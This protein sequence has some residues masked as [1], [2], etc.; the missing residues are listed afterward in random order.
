MKQVF[1]IASKDIRLIMRDKA[2]LFWILGFPI[3]LA[4]FFGAIFGGEGPTA[5]MQVTVIDND[6]SARSKAFL[7]DL[8]KSESLKIDQ[9]PIEEARNLVRQG[10]R[11]AYLVIP[12]GFGEAP[13]FGPNEG[14][15]LEIGQD[16]KRK[17]EYGMLQGLVTQA[18]FKQ[19]QG[20]FSDP[21][22]MKKQTDSARASLGQSNMNPAQKRTMLSML[23]SI[24]SATALGGFSPS[25]MGAGMQ[26]P[27]IKQTVV[28]PKG[29]APASAFEISFPQG[30]LWGLI[31]VT[32]AFSVGIVKERTMG[33]LGRLRISPVTNAQLIAGK[34]VGCFLMIVAVMLGMFALGSVFGVRAFANPAAMV[35]AV[36]CSGVC[37]VGLAMFLNLFGKSEEAVGGA[38]RAFLL[39]MAMIGGGMIPVIAMPPWMVTASQISPI[40][41]T[42]AAM[43]GAIWRGY[44][45][46]EMML[47]CLILVLVGLG[48][49]TL[50]IWSLKRQQG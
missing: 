18:W 24:E 36:V 23:N 25:D 7:E 41:W 3:L 29:V 42:V 20:A 32:M 16:P 21:A 35:L 31:G 2:G 44:S 11:V 10:N 6:Q 38:G 28:S 49:F 4:V 50:G 22:E 9:K 5:A 39:I 43:E 33:T 30:I 45:L 12:K 15:A 1:A 17:A 13:L 8:R 47:P 26:G 34:A 46:Q 40:R 19:M 48:G 14:A 37:F 27:S